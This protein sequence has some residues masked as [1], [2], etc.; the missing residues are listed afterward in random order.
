MT[1]LKIKGSIV[2]K[3]NLSLLLMEFYK[4]PFYGSRVFLSQ[5]LAMVRI[6]T[7]ETGS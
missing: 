5:P 4:N 3:K 1:S 2:D 6:F 7:R